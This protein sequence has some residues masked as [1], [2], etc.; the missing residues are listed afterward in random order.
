M[1]TPP[2]MRELHAVAHKVLLQHGT[3]AAP[4]QRLAS[5]LRKVLE[6]SARMRGGGSLASLLNTITHDALDITGAQRACVVLMNGDSEPDVGASTDRDGTGSAITLRDLS[7][8]VIQR[9]A[10]ERKA[11]Y[12]HDVFEDAELMKS[13]SLRALSL[14]SA[15]CAPLMRGDELYG[16]MYADTTSAAAAFDAIDL[17][18]LRLFADQA[19]AAIESSKLVEDVQRSLTELKDVQ[20][21]LVKGERLR[22]M[23]ELSSGVAHEFNNLLTAILARIQMMGLSYLPSEAKRDLDLIEKAALDAAEVVRRLQSFSRQQRQA[24]FKT[25]EMGEICHDALELLRPLW[26]GRRGSAS[27]ALDVEL[28]AESGLFVRG[29]ATELREVLTNLVK[30]AIEAVGPD[31]RIRVVAARRRG[32]IQ[33]RVEDNGQGIPDEVRA[34]VFDP[35]FTTKGERGTGLGLC[36]SQQIVQKHSGEISVE[37]PADGGTT[38]Q[39]YLPAVERSSLRELSPKPVQPKTHAAIKVVLVDDDAEVLKPLIRHLEESGFQ[40]LTAADG[41]KGLELA[42]SAN[43]NVVLTDIGMP[44]MDGLELCRRLHETRPS[45]PVVLMSGWASDVDHEH[46]RVSGAS[47]VVAKPFSLFAVRDLLIKLAQHGEA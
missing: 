9:A 34:R 33:V 41:L 32:R 24:D 46:A 35:F 18:V 6:V 20:D 28:H 36:L 10:E 16:V 43:P 19:A 1:D 11:L 39:F 45:L 37:A 8:T 29:D 12:W 5:A 15:L 40:V 44:G 27:G 38:I 31:G 25:L 4:D 2:R 14:R 13:S 3:T 26:R 47:G 42:S 7:T 21:R 17:E 22:V 23:G 30:N